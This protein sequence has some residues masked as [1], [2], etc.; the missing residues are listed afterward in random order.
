MSDAIRN[1]SCL[2]QLFDFYDAFLQVPSVTDKLTFL[3]INIALSRQGF[4]LQR[5]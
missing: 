2:L 5:N 3:W 4:Y 1:I